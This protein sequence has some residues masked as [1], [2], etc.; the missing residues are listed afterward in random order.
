M[1]LHLKS[2]GIDFT[3]FSDATE[4]SELLDDYEEGT[5]SPTMFGNSAVELSLSVGNGNYNK[6]S[7]LV[8]V[9]GNTVCTNLNSATGH[10]YVYALPFS[11]RSQGSPGWGHG[12]QCNTGGLMNQG[13]IHGITFA[14]EPG[15][16]NIY[17]YR[18]DALGT[19]A[20]APSAFSADG[21]MNFNA[22]YLTA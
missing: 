15:N 21:N 8:Y 14:N 10:L 17:M 18:S 4:A 3:D 1:A 2:T 5:W 12:G 13:D 20:F 19:S 7:A 6:Q 22:M 11:G 9:V 16:A